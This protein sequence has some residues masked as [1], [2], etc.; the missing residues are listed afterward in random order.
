MCEYRYLCPNCRQNI[1]RWYRSSC[2]NPDCQVVQIIEDP[3]PKSALAAQANALG[4]VSPIDTRILCQSCARGD[5]KAAVGPHIPSYKSLSSS[6]NAHPPESPPSPPS[7]RYPPIPYNSTSPTAIIRPSEDATH[8]VKGPHVMLE[9]GRSVRRDTGRRM[10]DSFAPGLDAPSTT[11]TSPRAHDQS[12]ALSQFGS[13]PTLAITHRKSSVTAA[14]PEIRSSSPTESIDQAGSRISDAS[15]FLPSPS[16]E[17]GMAL[18][19][20]LLYRDESLQNV[21]SIPSM[22]SS[23]DDE[24]RTQSQGFKGSR[25]SGYTP[26]SVNFR[27]ETSDLDV[28]RRK[29]ARASTPPMWSLFYQGDDEDDN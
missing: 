22:T 9:H 21:E 1:I 3:L 12:S 19:A 2:G 16:S 13:T 28:L 11:M 15:I 14:Q 8:T 6:F 5:E 4:S 25:S 24:G 29:R 23:S 7:Y 17:I 20:P 27:R 10:V 18:G 26:C